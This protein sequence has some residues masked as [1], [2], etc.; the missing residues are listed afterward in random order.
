MGNVVVFGCAGWIGSE[1]FERLDAYGV[2]RAEADFTDADAVANALASVPITEPM[3]VIHAGGRSINGL[4]KDYGDDEFQTSL[5]DNLTA[6]F[7]IARAFHRQ[8]PMPGSTLTFMSSIVPRV[9]VRGTVGYSASKAALHGLTKTAAAEF[10]PDYRVNCLEL[11]YFEGGII[12]TVPPKMLDKVVAS[13]PLRRLGD[14]NSIEAAV[15]F[16]MDAEFVTGAIV[17]VTGGL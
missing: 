12:S 10:A 16:L 15:L 1:L 3:H 4:I 13:I 14:I 9:G 8:K 7:V 11:G 2:S 5:A 17:P 6:A